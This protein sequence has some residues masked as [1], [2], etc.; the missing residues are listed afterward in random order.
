MPIKKYRSLDEA[1]ADQ[2]S[3]PGS[4]TNIRRMTFVLDF[5]SRVRPKT[6]PRGVFKYR[7]IEEAQNDGFHGI[8]H[9]TPKKPG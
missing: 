2:R 5:W 7:S 4:E 9:Q 6:V 3:E 8:G 1:K